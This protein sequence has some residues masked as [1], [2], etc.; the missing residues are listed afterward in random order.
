VQ[1]TSFTRMSG[2][3]QLA[4][5]RQRPWFSV[6]TVLGWAAR[7]HTTMPFLNHACPEQPSNSSWGRWF[8][9]LQAPFQNATLCGRRESVAHKPNI[10]TETLGWSDARQL[11]GECFSQPVELALRHR[12]LPAHAPVLEPAHR[13]NRRLRLQLPPPLPRWLACC[14][15]RRRCQCC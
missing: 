13:P 2:E 15:I 7:C 9:S 8:V 14:Q 6:A 5:S 12:T 1:S 11:V 10:L 3:A 4:R